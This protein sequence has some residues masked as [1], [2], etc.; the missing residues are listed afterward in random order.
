[1]DVGTSDNSTSADLLAC[2]HV[3]RVT[4]DISWFSTATGMAQFSSADH[5]DG[6][7]GQG[8]API[9]EVRTLGQADKRPSR[10]TG[11]ELSIFQIGLKVGFFA[12][13]TR[14]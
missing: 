9:P 5:Q 4:H 3:G 14:E 7:N 13:F 8:E 1:M 12:G 11:G 2:W 10:R 6:V